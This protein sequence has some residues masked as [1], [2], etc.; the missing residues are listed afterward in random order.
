VQNFVRAPAGLKWPTFSNFTALEL[1]HVPILL[2][3]DF[4]S[5]RRTIDL[6]KLLP[7]SLK[8]LHIFDAAYNTLPTRLYQLPTEPKSDRTYSRIHTSLRRE[9]FV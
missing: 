6:I 5:E 9:G 8:T 3:E 2:F 7:P 1:L 4:T